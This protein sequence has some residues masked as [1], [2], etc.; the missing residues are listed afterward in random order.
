MSTACHFQTDGQ[1]ERMHQTLE[2][3]FRLYAGNHKYKW[4]ELLPTTQRQLINHKTK[5]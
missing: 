5:T 2:Q 3:Y 1:T 4:V